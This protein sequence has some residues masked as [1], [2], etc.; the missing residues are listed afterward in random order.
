MEGT[1]RDPIQYQGLEIGKKTPII[2]HY[3]RESQQRTPWTPSHPPDPVISGELDDPTDMIADR[4]IAVASPEPQIP[5]P[6]GDDD[7]KV[8]KSSSAIYSVSEERERSKDRLARL[9]IPPLPHGN[10]EVIGWGEMLPGYC[11]DNSGI[12]MAY[13]RATFPSPPTTTECCLRTCYQS[14]NGPLLSTRPP[15]L[16]EASRAS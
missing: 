3:N 8:S 7:S 4:E 10:K 16:K 13:M 9:D 2:F 11:R 15:L 14:F 6:H 1:F 12:T 5:P